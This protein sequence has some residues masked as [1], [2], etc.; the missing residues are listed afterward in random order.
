[1]TARRCSR[2]WDEPQAGGRLWWAI[3]I[4]PFQCDIRGY[5]VPP[6]DLKPG[7]I[8]R[9][10]DVFNLS[11]LQCILPLDMTFLF[12]DTHFNLQASSH[13]PDAFLA[14][15]SAFLARLRPLSDQEKATRA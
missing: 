13:Q 14:K 8:Q 15:P 4:T 7:Q 9:R 3:S 1:M 2:R 5:G 6:Q 10:A 12:P 11:L